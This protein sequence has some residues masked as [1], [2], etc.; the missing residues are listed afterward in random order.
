MVTLISCQKEEE[1]NQVINQEENIVQELTQSLSFM[2]DNQS[3]AYDKLKKLGDIILQCSKYENVRNTI[4]SN[5]ENKFDGENEV[6]IKTLIE[7][8][9]ISNNSEF[10]SSTDLENIGI[11]LAA[12]KNIESQNYFPQIFIPFYDELKAKGKLNDGS[13]IIVPFVSG[14]EN[15]NGYIGYTL[16][17]NFKIEKLNFLID[18]VFAQNNEVWVISLNEKVNSDGQLINKQTKSL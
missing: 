11:N 10:V 6:L 1:L 18:E 2:N 13:P 5:I 14:T 3:F 9:V 15:L 17:S 16:N 7:K 4:Y 8:K 12:F